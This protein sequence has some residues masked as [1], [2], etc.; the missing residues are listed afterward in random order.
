MSKNR[1]IWQEPVICASPVPVTTTCSCNFFKGKIT[2]TGSK[3]QL[4]KYR[5]QNGTGKLNICEQWLSFVTLLLITLLP[6]TI[7]EWATKLVHLCSDSNLYSREARNRLKRREKINIRIRNNRTCKMEEI[8]YYRHVD[9]KLWQVLITLCD[10]GKLQK[11]VQ[12]STIFLQIKHYGWTHC[13]F[14]FNF[15]VYT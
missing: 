8:L 10:Y 12:L 5:C 11:Q 7:T 9:G 14:F 4:A 1:Q 3:I 2:N 15:Y 13:H 6:N